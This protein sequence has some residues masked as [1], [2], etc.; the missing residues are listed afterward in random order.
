MINKECILD[1]LS[2]GLDRFLYCWALLVILYLAGWQDIHHCIVLR[3]SWWLCLFI[4]AVL[5]RL[6]YSYFMLFTS[7]YVALC[8]AKPIAL[9]RWIKLNLHRTLF[10][11]WRSN[12]WL[13]N[14]IVLDF[15]GVLH[16]VATECINLRHVQHVNKLLAAVE[17]NGSRQAAACLLIGLCNWCVWRSLD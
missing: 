3:L 10:S 11:F 1:Y 9:W 15:T 7:F 13:L 5:L 14:E 12:L 2:D 16:N 4:D 8:T 17:G 6:C